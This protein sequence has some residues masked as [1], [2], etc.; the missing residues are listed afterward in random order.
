MNECNGFLISEKSMRES[1]TMN[2]ALGCYLKRVLAT[3]SVYLVSIWR[4]WSNAPLHI[5][6]KWCIRIIGMSMSLRGYR[7]WNSN[8]RTGLALILP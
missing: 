4:G 2:S 5:V 8:L 1:K 3:P 6:D 7:G